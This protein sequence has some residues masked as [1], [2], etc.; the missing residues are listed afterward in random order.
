MVEHVH[1]TPSQTKGQAS[2][3]I[4]QC[5]APAHPSLGLGTFPTKD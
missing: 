2:A 1:D 4:G 3:R 5:L